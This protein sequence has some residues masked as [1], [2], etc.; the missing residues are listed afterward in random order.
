MTSLGA[1][2]P[3]LSSP[4][5]IDNRLCEP[6]SHVRTSRL[7]LYVKYNGKHKLLSPRCCCCCCYFGAL[8]DN[9]DPHNGWNFS[10]ILF[11]RSSLHSVL[12][13]LMRTEKQREK[14]FA[15]KSV[16]RLYFFVCNATWGKNKVQDRETSHSYKLHARSLNL[17][18]LHISV[19]TVHLQNVLWERF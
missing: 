4:P 2:A 12:F 13:Y 9:N 1:F 17:N 14:K 11:D 16:K 19:L 18:I 3:R 10:N 7:M 6:M 5:P 15:E 8:L